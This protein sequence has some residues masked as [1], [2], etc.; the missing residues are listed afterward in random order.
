VPRS[1]LVSVAGSRDLN[2]EAIALAGFDLAFYRQLVRNG[3]EQPAALQPIRRWTVNPQIYLRTVDDA[4]TALDGSTLDR[5]EAVIRES[6]AQWT[7]GNYSA[8][9]ERGAGTKDGVPGWITINW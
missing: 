1:V 3:Y 4:G 6:V 7:N 2:V 8:L 5:T 9:V